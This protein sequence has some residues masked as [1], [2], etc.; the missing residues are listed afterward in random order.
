MNDYRAS[1]TLQEYLCNY[2]FKKVLC[3]VTYFSKILSLSGKQ[4]SL[5]DLS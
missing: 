2:F 5:V 4:P 3:L 1:A